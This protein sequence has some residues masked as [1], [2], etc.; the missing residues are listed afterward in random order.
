MPNDTAL[1]CFTEVGAGWVDW[2]LVVLGAI[3]LAIATERGLFLSRIEDDIA[4]RRTAA[5]LRLARES[6]TTRTTLARRLRVLLA[7]GPMAA[8]LGLLGV[9][10]GG[11]F[12][13]AAVGLVVGVPAAVLHECLQAETE[14]QLASA[15]AFGRELRDGVA[16][17]RR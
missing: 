14:A 17:E 2:P 11:G 7:V 9:M 5:L 3:T 1:T 10:L 8:L 4:G 13:V 12:E 16:K 15:E 6:G